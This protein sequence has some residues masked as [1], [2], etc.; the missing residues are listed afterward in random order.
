[1]GLESSRATLVA[2]DYLKI[3]KSNGIIVSRLTA[4]PFPALPTENTA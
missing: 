2:Q 4:A 1:M 3:D